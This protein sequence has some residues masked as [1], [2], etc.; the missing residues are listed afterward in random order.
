MAALSQRLVLCPQVGEGAVEGW[1][2]TGNVLEV[3]STQTELI[4]SPPK[5]CGPLIFRRLVTWLLSVIAPCCVS[6]VIG[7]FRDSVGGVVNHSMGWFQNFQVDSA[8]DIS[9]DRSH[10]PMCKV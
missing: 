1:H 6:A 7:P 8:V 5:L 4:I 10:H 3:V 9:G 2:A